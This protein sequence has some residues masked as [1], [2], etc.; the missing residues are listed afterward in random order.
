MTR[1]KVTMNA[2][3][4]KLQP[5]NFKHRLARW[6]KDMTGQTTVAIEPEWL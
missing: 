4:A 5:K 1:P 3:G 6:M 2:P